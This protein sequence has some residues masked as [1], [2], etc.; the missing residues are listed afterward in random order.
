MLEEQ[1]DLLDYTASAWDILYNTVDDIRFRTNDAELIFEA[2][3]KK[4]QFI[5][6]GEYLKRYVYEQTGMEAPFETVT[7][8]E[9]RASIVDSFR[10]TGTPA[11]FTD[12]TGKLPAIVKLWLNRHTV[13]RK[14]VF[15]LGFGL[16]MSVEHVNDFL[17]K[18]IREQGI[19]AKNPFE[20]ICWY[21]FKNGYGYPKFERLWS[22]Y[23][24]SSIGIQEPDRI[25]GEYTVVLRHSLENIKSD[26]ALLDYVYS[27]KTPENRSRVSKSM[28][29]AFCGLYEKAR[30]VAADDLNAMERER[31][32]DF[33]RPE[34]RKAGRRKIWTPEE[35]TGRDLEKVLYSSIP[36]DHHGNL[37]PVKKS[38]L[39]EKFDGYRIGRQRMAD[40]LSGKSEAN[41][42]D[43]ITLS[44]FVFSHEES[45][46]YPNRHKRYEAYIEYANGL[47]ESCYLSQLYITNPYEC[48]ILMCVLSDDPLGT[49]LD[50]N[51]I[52]YAENSVLRNQEPG[53]V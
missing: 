35:I 36:L 31:W 30:N 23:E 1:N 50:V 51:E 38:R 25:D 33:D 26:A 32:M 14:V 22:R 3:E 46:R 15:L 37:L 42:Q 5:P 29:D 20:V 13:G 21:C 27:L 17:R 19:N 4:I 39:R 18:G 2:L 16:S 48:F 34:N 44:F 7:E 11:S 41:R 40:I 8:E 53:G 47:L 52:D 9:F 24:N 45:D 10:D 49:F 28:Y 43:L 12:N 6:F